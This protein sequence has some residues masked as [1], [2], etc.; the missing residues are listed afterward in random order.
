[1]F[2][3][4]NYINKGDLKMNFSKIEKAIGELNEFIHET[5]ENKNLSKEEIALTKIVKE[6]TEMLETTQIIA[7]AS[8]MIKSIKVLNY[9]ENKLTEVVQ[10]IDESA[11]Q[12]RTAAAKAQKT[13]GPI[14]SILN[15][16]QNLKQEAAN[17][18][19]MLIKVIKPEFEKAEKTIKALEEMTLL[20]DKKYG[21]SKNPET[22]KEALTLKDEI[23]KEI[24]QLKEDLN[25]YYDNAM[26]LTKG[27]RK[28]IVTGMNKLVKND[29][30]SRAQAKTI[31]ILYEIGHQLKLTS[32][33]LHEEVKAAFE[34]NET[35]NE[36]FDEVSALIMQPKETLVKKFNSYF[37]DDV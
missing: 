13:Q 36:F 21:D 3:I 27:K 18:S 2:F 10:K 14:S 34:L 15:E 33:E 11:A 25:S 6:S 29:F 30:N 9:D 17:K 32:E 12:F 16:I 4:R 23:Q 19:E 28:G 37:A 7:K 5:G 8:D 22:L 20:I 35:K 1:M 26:L 31:N 24:N